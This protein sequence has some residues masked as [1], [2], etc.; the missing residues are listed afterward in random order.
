M[1]EDIADVLRSF[2]RKERYWVVQKSF[3]QQVACL[4]PEFWEELIKTFGERIGHLERSRTWWAIDYHFDWLIGAV[5]VYSAGENGYVVPRQNRLHAGGDPLIRR[6]QEDIDLV[7]ASGR[8][9]ILIEAKAFGA[10]SSQQLES[11]LERLNLLSEFSQQIDCPP[12]RRVRFHFALMSPSPPQQKN[13]RGNLRPW[14]R[15]SDLALYHMI[16]EPSL[17]KREVRTVGLS[18]DNTFFVRQ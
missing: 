13:I 18:A 4:C 7:L 14:A 5:H 11:K 12:D 2:N 8:D 10:W 3:G 15:D 6:Q 1:S 17:H 16:M 9:I